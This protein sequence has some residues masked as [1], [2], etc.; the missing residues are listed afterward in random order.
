MGKLHNFRKTKIKVQRWQIYS[1]KR[2]FAESK[3][4]KLKPQFKFVDV[5][6]HAA[7]KGQRR[8]LRKQVNDFRVAKL[9][10]DN[11]SSYKIEKVREYK[12]TKFNT[13]RSE[14][15]IYGEV[16]IFQ[17]HNVLQ[18]L[19]DKMTS[20]SPEN[21]KPSTASQ[22]YNLRERSHSLQLPEHSAHL[23]DCNFIIRM[24]YQNTY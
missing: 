9:F 24:L 1:V 5:A 23:S 12:Y 11:T 8:A 20:D 16:D 15:K 18:E 6:Q 22:R 13:T 21:V 7:R 17:M 19:V 14:Y 3:L 10:R 4:Q 2:L